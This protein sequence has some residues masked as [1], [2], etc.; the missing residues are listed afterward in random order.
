[1][2][3]SRVLPGFPLALSL[4]GFYIFFLILLTLGILFIHFWHIPLNEIVE[5]LINKRAIAAFRISVGLSILASMIAGIIGTLIAWTLVRYNFPFKRVLEAAVEI[6]FALPTAVSGITLATIYSSSGWLGKYLHAAGIDVSYTPLGIILALVFV[7][8]PFV[9]RTL[10]P[11]IQEL[12]PEWEEA[13]ACLGAT[14]GQTLRKVIFPQLFPPI[15][16]GFTLALARALGE[17]GSVIF[18][19]GNLPYV[20]EIVPL[21]IVIKLEEYDEN[22]AITLAVGMLLLSGIIILLLNTV[23]HLMAKKVY[24]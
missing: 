1:M 13:A 7:G 17:Y 20:S 19:A 6:P 3:K 18:I 12:E 9:V 16:S 4:T 15:I 24:R 8:L 5:S 21:L 10:E 2:K 22:A 11:A 14:H 23:Q